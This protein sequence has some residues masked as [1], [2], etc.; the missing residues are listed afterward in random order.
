MFL[1]QYDSVYGSGHIG[2]EHGKT[3]RRLVSAHWE[4]S[5]Q[6]KLD[7]PLFVMG[8]QSSEKTRLC[9]W[10]HQFEVFHHS[11]PSRLPQDRS[12][13]HSCRSPTDQLGVS[14]WS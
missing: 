10:K 12:R 13:G 14:A 5:P 3:L 7:C 9:S 8:F 1:I 4:Q 6:K 11:S 2:R